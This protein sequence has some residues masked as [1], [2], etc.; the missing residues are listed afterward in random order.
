LGHDIVHSDLIRGLS[1]FDPAVLLDSPED[2]YRDCMERL[3]S[4]FLEYGWLAANSKDLVISQ[5]RSFVTK[6]RQEK[7]NPDDWM[8]F[9]SSSYDM[10]N[11]A[12]LHLVFKYSCLCVSREDVLQDPFTISF[13]E[14]RGD[15]QEMKSCVRS[16]QSA[17]RLIPNVT[18]IFLHPASVPK[19]FPLLKR[20]PAILLDRKFSFWNLSKGSSNRRSSLF[21]QLESCYCRSVSRDELELSRAEE[22][23]TSSTV[24]YAAPS[25]SANE[26][27]SPNLGRAVLSVPRCSDDPKFLGGSSSGEKN[28]KKVKKTPVKK[29]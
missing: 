19:V 24:A 23:G 2:H 17:F 4:C 27:V 9:L 11:R 14:F 5:Y 22:A 1:S 3:V 21:I 12:E 6:I 29:S 20:N 16:L 13:S 15:V 7:V 26:T 10:R 18:S 8:E 25:S 28:T